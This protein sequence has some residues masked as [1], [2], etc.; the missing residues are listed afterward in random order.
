[1]IWRR[2]VPYASATDPARAADVNEAIQKSLLRVRPY[3][4]TPIAASLDDLYYFLS[5]D[6]AMAVERTR[7]TPKHVV[8]IT[9]GLP[10]LDYRDFNCDCANDISPT[11]PTACG[12]AND[13]QLMHCPY[14]TPEQAARTL[15]CGQ[16]DTERCDS[17]VAQLHVIGFAIAGD[18][19]IIDQLDAIAIAGVTRTSIPQTLGRELRDALD[20]V[21]TSI[22]P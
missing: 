3:G 21:L 14:P 11:D 2:R 19:R 5:Q 9:D 8:L 20:E 18:S 12:A 6:S 1:M 13:P 10:D 22:A 7:A 16:Q 4:G 17:S 15:R